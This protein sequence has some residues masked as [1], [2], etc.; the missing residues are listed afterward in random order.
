MALSLA[1]QAFRV[2]VV[3]RHGQAAI[4]LCAAAHT[5]PSDIDLPGDLGGQRM[6][7]VKTSV[8]GAAELVSPIVTYAGSDEAAVAILKSLR[9][10]IGTADARLA[11]VEVRGKPESSAFH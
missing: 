6:Q 8:L 11:V 3:G 9:K 5:K 10:A 2:S 7:L 4:D 1:S